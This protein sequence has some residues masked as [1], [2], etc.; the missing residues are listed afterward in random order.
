MY[1]TAHD[2]GKCFL[3]KPIM[4]LIENAFLSF[5]IVAPKKYESLLDHVSY[6]SPKTPPPPPPPNH[7]SRRGGNKKQGTNTIMSISFDS[8]EILGKLNN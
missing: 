4:I 2:R 6:R 1:I 7:P 5:V 8:A 3:G